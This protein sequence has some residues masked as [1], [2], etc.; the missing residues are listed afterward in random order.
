M[1]R[2]SN[3]PL[4]TPASLSPTRDDLE[5]LCTL[6][7]AA[8]R[9]GDEI[10]LMVRVGERAREQ[11][12]AF[13]TSV[14][15]DPAT[16]EPKILRIRHDDPDYK[17]I[18]TRIMWYQ[19]KSILTSMSHL[20]LARSS[21]NG[22]TFTF[23]KQP[24]IFP[25]TPYEAYGCEDA[26]ITFINGQYFIT[27]TAVSSRGVVV[28][29]AYTKDFTTFERAGVILPP[30]QK[31]VCIFPEK[32][33]NMYVCRHRPWRSEFNDP[34][35]WTAYSPDLHAWG[36]HEVT[37]EPAPNSWESDRVGAGAPPIRTDHG[38][39]DIYHA[40]DANGR[41]CLGAMLSELDHP[42]RITTRSH[43]PVMQPE[44]P[45]ELAGVYGNCVF[46]NGMIADADGK[47]HI[48]YGAADSICA[49]ATT[50]VA[51]MVASAQNK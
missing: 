19:G 48:Y 51:D 29:M 12:P 45:Y 8:V 13:I 17:P 36:N 37:L 5:V 35:I 49:A 26:R 42:E 25:A 47:L 2:W 32:V 30:F 6:N 3:N 27:Y 18:D 15:M 23:D 16:G 34:S 31:D 43:R 14:Q 33:R 46:S 24:A 21:D 28:A 38:W 1:R 20:R 10:L 40:A 39:L 44:A 11:S 41:Y 7:P 4:L 9:F 50:T 22:K